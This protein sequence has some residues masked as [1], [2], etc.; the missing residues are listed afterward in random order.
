MYRLFI[1]YLYENKLANFLL[2]KYKC[3]INNFYKSPLK[4]SILNKIKL[5]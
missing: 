2:L 4:V 3:H 1:N 5:I